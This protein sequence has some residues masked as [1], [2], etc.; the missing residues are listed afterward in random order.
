MKKLFAFIVVSILCFNL[1]ATNNTSS[2]QKHLLDGEEV[3]VAPDTIHLYF[4]GCSPHGEFVTITNNTSNVLVIER[5]YSDIYNVEC[6]FEGNNVN[7]EGMFVS[8]GETIELQVFVSVLGKDELDSY[9]NLFI[10]T[11]LGV[12]TVTIYHENYLSIE[13]YQTEFEV[14]PNPANDHLTLKAT[15]LGRVT[16]FNALGQLMDEFI[17]KNDEIVIPTAHYPNGIYFVQTDLGK[18]Q[19]FIVNH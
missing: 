7:D 2:I 6:L 11:D 9:G 15:G 12:F 19:R 16:L 10:D 1:H 13:D 17:A 4:H 8:A 5:F 3:I 18:I 14:Y